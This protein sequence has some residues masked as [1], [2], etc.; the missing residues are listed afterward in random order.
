MRFEQRA[1]LIGL[2]IQLLQDEVRS[3]SFFI[4]SSFSSFC[5][6]CSKEYFLLIHYLITK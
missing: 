6:F 5:F 2:D 4:S 1:M 3:L